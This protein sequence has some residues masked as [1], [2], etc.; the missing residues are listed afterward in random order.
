MNLRAEN[1]LFGAQKSKFWKYYKIYE[2][3][4]FEA[5]CHIFSNELLFHG[6]EINEP[7]RQP[8][9]SFEIVTRPR[10]PIFKINIEINYTH[11]KSHAVAK[12]FRVP[13]SQ[14]QV[15]NM[16]AKSL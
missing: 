13:F 7:C 16:F 8:E 10:F 3:R 6:F 9:C 5:K 15:S 11:F 12:N 1:F 4:I 2:V 14:A